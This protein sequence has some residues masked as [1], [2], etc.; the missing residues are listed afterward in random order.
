MDERQCE[1]V[2]L[3]RYGVIAELVSRPLAPGEK[4]RLRVPI[5]RNNA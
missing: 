1:E 2:A 3:F 4:Q 5:D